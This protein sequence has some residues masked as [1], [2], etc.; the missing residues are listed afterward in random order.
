MP[1]KGVPYRGHRVGRF[2]ILER[3]AVGGMGEIFLAL[4]RG[5][6]EFERLVVV[7]QLLPDSARR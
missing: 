4:E 5:A 3:I 1:A 7:K 6:A 2:E